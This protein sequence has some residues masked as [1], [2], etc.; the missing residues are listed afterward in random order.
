MF[1]AYYGVE[2]DTL[3]LY[4]VIINMPWLM[5]MV[6]G[7]IIDS[8]VVSRRKYYLIVFGI[9]ATMTQLLIAMDILHEKQV[10]VT[11]VLYSCSAAFLDAV[12]D[13]TII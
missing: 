2:P 11:L 4:K 7:L 13:A 1:R 9:T 6:F 5:K 8:K 3:Q 10:L 12:V